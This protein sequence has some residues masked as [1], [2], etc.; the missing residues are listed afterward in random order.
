MTHF[1]TE[2][3][4]VRSAADASVALGEKGRDLILAHMRHVLGIKPA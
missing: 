3:W 4:Y 1:S 2:Q